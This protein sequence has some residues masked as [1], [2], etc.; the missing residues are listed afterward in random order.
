[1]WKTFAPIVAGLGLF[2]TLP[3]LAVEK[4][5]S[6]DCPPDGPILRAVV[7]KGMLRHEKV[8]ESSS[9]LLPRDYWKVIAD[10]KTYYLDL[11]GKELLERAENLVN[12][13]VVV[14]GIPEPASP[15]LRV[16]SLKPDEFVKETINVEVRGR[17]ES[18][19]NWVH[20]LAEFREPALP[21]PPRDRYPIII[22]WQ[23]SLGEKSYRLDFGNRAELLNL[24]HQL[25]HKGVIVTG[26][27][28]GEVIHVTALKADEGTYQETVTVEIQGV[29]TNTT[30]FV[31]WLH[32]KRNPML[33][34]DIFSMWYV[35]VNEK[36]YQLDFS[37]KPMPFARLT[38]LQDRTVVVTGTLKDGVVTVTSLTPVDPVSPGV[39]GV[40]D[41]SYGPVT[42]QYSR[43]EGHKRVRI[44]G[45]WVQGPRMVG[46][47][48]SG[49]FDPVNGVLEFAFEEPW[50]N[51]SGTAV[52]RLSADGNTLSGT[53]SYIGG[54]GGSWV[55]T[56][57]RTAPGVFDLAERTLGS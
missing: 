23:I 36:S 8:E 45:S 32:A 17:L 49:T 21:R 42:I 10:R 40:W 33:D 39:A 46:V 2:L 43:G 6:V 24:A 30:R 44:T 5:G 47:I 13:P 18:I 22:G 37:I 11:R 51:Q 31:E 53:W 7:L 3:A 27:R 28:V 55:M 34:K 48:T 14:T 41:S 29:L 54:G 50:H 38:E 16:T 12:R 15:T 25:D 52:F 9:S 4:S 56:R 1:M 20:L 19:R 35:T 26:T 57:P